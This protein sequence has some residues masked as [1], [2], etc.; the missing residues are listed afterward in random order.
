MPRITHVVSAAPEFRY[1]QE[2]IARFAEKLFPEADQRK[3]H[4][5][6]KNSQILS[7]RLAR[8]LEWFQDLPGFG[9]RNAAFQE[10]AIELSCR[11]VSKLLEESGSASKRIGHIFFVTTTGLSNPTLDTHLL[12]RLPLERRVFRTPIWGLGCAGGVASLSRASEWLRANPSSYALVVCVELCSLTLLPSDRSKSNLV[13]ACLFGDGCAAALLAGD[14]IQDEQSEKRELEILGAQSYTWPQSQEVMGWRF[15]DDGFQVVFSPEIPTLVRE[16]ARE[17]TEN[18]L[19]QH[20]SSLSEVDHFLSHPG[21]R[22]VVEAYEAA[23]GL[24]EE[25]F[26]HALAVLQQNGNMSSAT[27]LYVLERFLLKDNFQPGASV[28]S[29]GLGPGFSVEMLLSKAAPLSKRCE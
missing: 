3:L 19:S 17:S 22:K 25:Q 4:S 12:D 6:S 24:R 26:Q 28:L 8:P 10:T 27:V 13:A 21:G 14:E 2:E 9:E 15:Q 7:R 20:G 16:T 11:A 23:L 29:S 1:P 18:F 5:I